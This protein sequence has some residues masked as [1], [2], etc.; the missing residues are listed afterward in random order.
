MN[1]ENKTHKVICHDCGGNGYRRDCYGEVYQCKNCK[2]QGEIAFTEEEML[3]KI[4]DV[5]V[6][7]MNDKSPND[8]EKKIYLLERANF[9]LTEENNMLKEKL[10]KLPDKSFIDKV[11]KCKE[12]M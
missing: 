10:K 4:G 11:L 7:A 3:E 2:S 9:R 12:S 6:Y 5:G 8:L 1:T